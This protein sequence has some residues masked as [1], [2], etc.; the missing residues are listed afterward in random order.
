MKNVAL[1]IAWP[2]SRRLAALVQAEP[3]AFWLDSASA[4][5]P[6]SRISILALEPLEHRACKDFAE[7]FEFAKEADA[8]LSFRGPEESTAEHRRGS[9][10]PLGT[11]GSIFGGGWIGRLNYEG[12]ADF[13]LFDAWL[14]LDH[15]TQSATVHSQ[16]PRKAD[17]LVRRL[18]A[19]APSLSAWQAGPIRPDISRAEYLDQVRDIQER[20]RR[21]DCYQVNLSQGFASAGRGDAADLYLRLRQAAPAP[22]MAYVNLGEEQIF[23]ASPEILL[24]SVG[25]GAR[26]YPIK[27]TRPR[28]ADPARDAELAAELLASPKDAAEL[29]MIVDLVRNDL[30]AVSRT[31]SVSVPELRRLESLPQV[32][33]LYAVVE[34]EL[35]AGIGPLQALHRLSPGGSITGAPKLK[36]IEVIAELERGPRGIYTGSIGYAGFSGR[37]GFNIAIRTATLKGGD[38][39]Y[40][41]GGG[42]VVDSEP[43]AEYRE[44]LDK[45]RGFFAALG[46]VPEGD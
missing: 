41:A 3:P 43:E 36:A 20:L 12:R 24:E 22:Q 26:S 21:G 42:I 38:L 5:H 25:R 29:L 19:A 23:S 32:H 35:A 4:G 7:F 8:Q 6:R 14:E 31:G 40:R 46:T 17:R 39:E 18:S 13:F 33:H 10:T 16:D 28:S 27:G 45:A 34:S 15:S 11:T 9:L 1:P 44:C 37:S 30:G 2:D